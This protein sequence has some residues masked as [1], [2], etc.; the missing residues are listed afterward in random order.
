MLHKLTFMKNRRG[1][2]VV[3]ILVLVLVCTFF[4]DPVL[5]YRN[6]ELSDAIQS[7]SYKSGT[8][9][10]D[11]IPFEWDYVYRFVPYTPK[12]DME[13]KMGVRSRY[14][15]EAKYDDMVQ[16]YVVKNNKIIAFINEKIDIDIISQMPEVVKC[17][18]NRKIGE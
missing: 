16:I 2:T 13:N 4:I 8:T 15:T 11:V 17:G 5:R 18:T 1:K 6:H 12:E 14:V 7:L 10:E 3:C 9:L